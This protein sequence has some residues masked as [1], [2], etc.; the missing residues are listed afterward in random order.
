MP[1]QDYNHLFVSDFHIAMGTHPT[2][3][4]YNPREDFHYD[5]HFFRFLQWADK[6]RENGKLWELIF[7]GDCFDFLPV[8]VA[9]MRQHKVMSKKLSQ[10]LTQTDAEKALDVWGQ[11]F[12]ETEIPSALRKELFSDFVR[13]EGMVSLVPEDLERWVKENP[14]QGAGDEAEFDDLME[15][16]GDEDPD[17]EDRGTENES[18]DGD[19]DDAHPCAPYLFGRDLGPVGEEKS[20]F[21]D[22]RIPGKVRLPGWAEEVVEELRPDLF[23]NLEKDRGKYGVFLRPGLARDRE[24]VRRWVY[25]LRLWWKRQEYTFKY[26]QEL[27]FK[28]E[29]SV[30]K[31]CTIYWGHPKFFEALAWW[32]GR[33]HRLVVMPGNHDLEIN[34]K[35]VQDKFKEL[36]EYDYKDG[37]YKKWHKEWLSNREPDEGEELWGPPEP[38]E[39]DLRTFKKMIE[40]VD[41]RAFKER[42]D[43]GYQWFYY[44]PGA[45][46]AEHGAQYDNVN[47]AV[48]LLHPFWTEPDGDGELLNPS[49]G[50]LGSPLVDRLEDS[51]PEWENVGSHGSTL[52]YMMKEYPG[53]FFRIV[54]KNLKQYGNLILFLLE[55]TNGS[56]KEQ[57]PSDKQ[58]KR[59]QG[60]PDHSSLP[61]DFMRALYY[62]WDQPLLLYRRLAR[63]VARGMKALA[64]PSSILSYGV[65]CLRILLSPRGL[66]IF[67][68][69]LLVGT[70]GWLGDQIEQIQQFV[71]TDGLG[72]PVST[73]VSIVGPAAVLFVLGTLASEIKETIIV[74]LKA[75]RKKF[76]QVALFGMHEYMEEAGRQTFEIFEEWAAKNKLSEEDLPSYYIFGHDHIPYKHVLKKKGPWSGKNVYYINTGSWLSWFAREDTRRL[77]TGGSDLEF[78]FLKIWKPP[79]DS[80]WDYYEEEY[81]HSFLR[82]NDD[83]GRPEDQIVI[84]PE[85]EADAVAKLL[86]APILFTAGLGAAV[87]FV[88]DT[89]V[90][91]W[92]LGATYGAAAG[93]L[94]GWALHQGIKRKTSKKGEDRFED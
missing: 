29:S 8:E 26:Y 86:A 40:R 11:F 28:Q 12:C 62:S 3:K 85:R 20:K 39:E 1:G 66:L 56:L 83:A 48:N 31:L 18:E 82:W 4:V 2:H 75:K 91:T 67:V 57:G 58:Y 43:F 37:R 36:L 16:E 21:E 90:G 5:N 9:W 47:S 74:R 65:D 27:F 24:L 78:T 45:F 89:Q 71:K 35:G 72:E 7:V 42:V 55:G 41:F 44:R 17:M 54:A 49:F 13:E 6:N 63:I 33:G 32:V 53:R 80:E 94:I 10:T 76:F 73:I 61:V 23:S 22:V 38:S 52:S 30:E 84:A 25:R 87:G 46:Y 69:L 70:R 77:R 14:E 81:K 79:P 34:W 15:L 50:N 92:W 51:Y 88:V 60:L 19:F 93:G 68:L 59:Y 64:V